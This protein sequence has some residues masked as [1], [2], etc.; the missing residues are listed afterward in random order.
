MPQ[1]VEPDGRQFRMPQESFQPMVGRRR[2]HGNLRY[3]WVVENPI[4]EEFLLPLLKNLHRAGRQQDGSG[5][6]FRLGFA[7]PD[8]ATLAAMDRSADVEP[9]GFLLEVLP[10]EAADFPQS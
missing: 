7:H 1:I 4:A 5:T 6:C 2:I 10:L 3:H 8:A 9:P